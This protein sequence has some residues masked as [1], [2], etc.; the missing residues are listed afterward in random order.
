MLDIEIIEKILTIATILLGLIGILWGTARAL[1][2]HYSRFLFFSGCHLLPLTLRDDIVKENPQLKESLKE[3]VYDP[4]V[5]LP[6]RQMQFLGVKNGGRVVLNFTHPQ[7]EERVVVAY[8]YSYPDDPT[9]WD[10][11]DQPALSMGLRRYFGLERP[12]CVCDGIIPEGWRIIEHGIMRNGRND[13]A[14]MHNVSDKNGKLIW[15]VSNEY[16]ASF[17]CPKRGAE[18]GKYQNAW[19]DGFFL[20]YVGIAL[21]ISKPSILRI[22]S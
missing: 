22:E 13:L 10:S 8:A 9:T 14:L 5:V 20:E 19:E 7:R 6:K 4:L 16:S 21:K 17:W 12:V 2:R 3:H 15:L 1:H 18:G 11:F